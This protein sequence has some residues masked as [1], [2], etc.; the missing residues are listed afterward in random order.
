[1]CGCGCIA[2][3]KQILCFPHRPLFPQSGLTCV[4]PKFSSLLA[5]TTLPQSGLTCVLGLP[6]RDMSST[7]LYSSPSL[8]TTFGKHNVSLHALRRYG[9]L[10]QSKRHSHDIANTLF[11]ILPCNR[12]RVLTF[13]HIAKLGSMMCGM[14]LERLVGC[15]RV[16]QKSQYDEGPKA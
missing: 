14:L 10:A 3:A 1:M 4:Y 7:S 5:K 15:V 2:T 13:Q 6:P 8:P 11:Q 16:C 9:C 12:S